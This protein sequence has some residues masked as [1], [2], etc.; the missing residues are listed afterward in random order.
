MIQEITQLHSLILEKGKLMYKS[1]LFKNEKLM[2]LE[3]RILMICK[4][5]RLK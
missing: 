2:K 1:L 3:L 5:K 4:G